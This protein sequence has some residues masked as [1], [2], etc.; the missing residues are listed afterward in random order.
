MSTQPTRELPLRH[1]SIRVPWHDNGWNGTVCKAPK[2]NGA[3]LVLKRIA[4]ERDDES[5]E[6]VAGRRIDQLDQEKRQFPA[7]VAERGFFMSPNPYVRIATHPYADTN[8]SSHQ[9]FASTPLTHPAY[10]A[11]AVP[12]RWLMKE[13][14]SALAEAFDIDVN[15]DLEPDL[16]FDT[17]WVQDLHNQKALSEYFFGHLEPEQSLCFFYVKKVPFLETEGRRI[18]VGVGKVNKVGETTEYKY[19]SKGKLR[20]MLWERMVSHSIRPGFEDGF[21]LPYQEL[22]ALAE[23]QSLD[24]AEFVAFAPDDRFDEFSYASELVTNDAA[25]ASLLSCA[26]AL[27]RSKGTI[28]GPWDQCLKWIDSQLSRLWRMRG[29][30]PGLGAALT[31]FGVP[32]GV[33]VARALSSRLGENEDP[34]PMVARMFENPVG[35]IPAN[36]AKEISGPLRAAWKNLAP[37]R[38]DLLKLLSRLDLTTDEAT[39][40]YVTEERRDA[41]LEFTDAEILANP[42]RLYEATRRSALPISVFTVDRG[43]FPEAVIREKHPLPE[44]SAPDGALDPRRIRALVVNI[45]ESMAADG[46]TLVPRDEVITELRR[47]PIQPAPEATQ[48]TIAIAEAAFV[49]EISIVE[50]ADGSPAYQLARL[51]EMDQIIRDQVS[52]RL[53]GKRLE[54]NAK[55]RELLDVEFGPT[56]EPEELRARDEKAAALKELAESRFS[57]LTGSAGTG[58]TTLLA[59]LCRHK[60]VAEGGIVFLAPTG[61]ARVRM[62]QAAKNLQ[63]PAYTLA[64]FL[65]P[66][67]YDSETQ[68]YKLSEQPAVARAA[69]VVVDESS[70]LTEEMLAALIQSLKGVRRLI[71]V[72]D[73]R[74]LPPIGPGRPFVDIVSKLEPP[75]AD[76]LSPCVAAGYA[77]LTV[78]RRQGGSERDDLRLANWFSGAASGPAEDDIFDRVISGASKHVQLARWDTPEQLDGLLS[79]TLVAEL[80]LK[81]PGDRLGFE[82]SIGGTVFNG[83]SYFNLGAAPK[84]ESWQ[85]LSPVRAHPHGV[86]QLNRAI[87]Q[88]FRASAID[89]ARPGDKV[90]KPAGSEEIVYGDKVIN[91]INHWRKYVYPKD[92]ALNYVA[93]GEIG[94]V[95]GQFRKGNTGAWPKFINVEFSSQAGF[96]YS[97][98]PSEFGEESRALLELAYALTV[99]KAQG[100]EFGLVILVLPNPCRV[101]SRELIYTALTR[102]RDRVV[103]L[104][105]GDASTL[106]PLASSAGSE[107]A[108][109]LTNLFTA[110]KL[111]EVKGKFLEERLINVTQRQE[112]VRSKSEVV[113]ANILASRGVDYE[114]EKQ[115]TLAGSTRFPDFTIEDDAS[116]KVYYWEHLGMLGDPAYR[117]RWQAKLAWYRENGI[118]PVDEGGGA[119][120]TLIVTADNEDG[121]INTPEIEKSVDAVLR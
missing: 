24:P 68:T 74:Q 52:R 23:D 64:Q 19:K 62:Q 119:N 103:I 79:K 70:M 2:L 43:S 29:P 109:R 112:L 20:S 67:R 111:V 118:L 5:E 69:T 78:Q 37:T 42:Y 76:A 63:I 80:T 1:I 75:N 26:A 82:Q 72:G 40:I 22:A 99:H 21:L 56:K 66:H 104:Y 53:E 77:R 10:S 36:L 107:T 115:L 3:C 81:G 87:H 34:W 32:R 14:A 58:K 57:V 35:M 45:L 17:T 60:E 90:P 98:R 46:H 18:I 49:G 71:L 51:A 11:P 88:S 15:W 105:Q 85:I 117:A 101:L 38:R 120:G 94:I 61:K 83:H 89:F 41:G 116:G 27:E 12:F 25:I 93:N 97:F 108:R 8:N 4:D 106:K 92:D 113:I 110:P 7:C 59:V 13:D 65:S 121:G 114:Y 50:M 48:D 96:S 16:G 102:Q 47:L 31:A 30:C 44:P 28:P 33:M 73:H 95:V 39:G 54:V 91:L 84:A 9:H 86:F 6:K 100:S 55:W